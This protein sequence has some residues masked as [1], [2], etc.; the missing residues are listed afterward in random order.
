MKVLMPSMISGRGRAGI[1]K[2]YNVMDLVHS[3]GNWWIDVCLMGKDG[4]LRGSSSSS[5]LKNY[6]LANWLSK[7]TV[8][9]QI[10]PS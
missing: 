6:I 5:Y 4:S 3:E 8:I 1:L 10:L 7:N 2:G 9:D